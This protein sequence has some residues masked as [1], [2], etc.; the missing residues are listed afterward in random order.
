MPQSLVN[1]WRS[2]PAFL[3]SKSIA[4]IV[5]IA[6]DGSLKDGNTT[7]TELRDFLSEAAPSQLEQYARECLGDSFPNSGL[8]LQDLVNEIGVRL[9]FDVQAGR[10]RGVKN[11]IGND[12]LWRSSGSSQSEAYDLVMELK[13]TNAYAIDLD[14]IANYRDR[15]IEE[16]TCTEDNSS[17]LLVVG[18][19]DTGGLE[20][21]IRGSRHAW[22]IRLI[23]VDSLIQLMHVKQKMND[24]ATSTQINK[25]LR[26]MEFTRLDGIIDLLFMTARDSD[27]E[28]ATEDEP[29]SAQNSERS[30]G[31]Y[32]P[33]GFDHDTARA[34]A[35]K[36]ASEK[37]GCDLKK[38]GRVFWAGKEGQVRIVCLSSQ[39][40]DDTRGNEYWYGFK[41]GQKVFL[42]EADQGYLLLTCGMDD[43]PLLIP[44]AE[45]REILK[46]LRTSVQSDDPEQIIHWHITLH[47]TGDLV[48]MKKTLLGGRQD[49]SRFILE[50]K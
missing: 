44:W 42:E 24:W 25:L 50:K 15:L 18:R 29:E 34:R 35:L 4:Q 14:T 30:S 8:V 40:Y 37:I 39:A 10:Y 27:D 3:E 32:G 23:S 5:T 13:T 45:F 19:N 49:I 31:T 1:I 41:P 36:L 28:G 20:A 48:E 9:D 26:P 17:I 38:K 11:E 16:D 22:D 2:D 47:H 43:S 12:G 6:G 21:Q 7:S 33:S 46:G